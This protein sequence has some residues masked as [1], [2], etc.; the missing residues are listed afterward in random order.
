MSRPADDTG[1]GAKGLAQASTVV[2]QMVVPIVAGV[3]LDDRY[4]WKPW[5]LVV[6]ALLGVGGGFL[7][8]VRLARKQG[9]SG[10]PPSANP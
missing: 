2:A 7:S 9:R 4:G 10:D 5:G 8:L 1:G 3:W 6:G